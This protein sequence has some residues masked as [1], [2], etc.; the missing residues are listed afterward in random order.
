MKWCS[1]FLALFLLQFPL[2]V[3]GQD[4]DILD[5][6]RGSVVLEASSEYDQSIWSALSLLDSTPKTGWCSAKGAAFP[7]EILLELP[8]T[9]LLE[10]I[11]ID[12]STAQES[13]YPGISAKDIEILASATSPT[14]G[15]TK[16]M[17]VVAPKGARKVF[18]LSNPTKARWLKLV[19]KSNWGDPNY[20][21]IMELEAYGKPAD[22]NP[23][24]PPLAGTF[25][26]NY[27]KIYFETQGNQVKGC[28]DWSGGVL[29]GWTDG[30]VVQFEWRQNK[31][32]QIGTAIMVVSAD[33]KKINGLWYHKGKL[34]GVWVG[35]RAKPGDSANCTVQSGNPVQQA[36]A[37]SGRL[38]TYGIQFDTNLATLKP[39]SKVVLGEVLGALQANP[40]MILTIEGHTDSSASET[41][42]QDLSNRRAQAVVAWLVA[43]GIPAERLKAK[44]FGE[45]RPIADNGTLQGRALNRRV[46]IVQAGKISG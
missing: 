17:D 34:Q 42:N 30:R 32:T 1:L 28:Y 21:E 7:H 26:T 11:V 43:K 4:Q 15:F 44:G 20:S 40:K 14:T 45:A 25:D 33:G 31:G 18:P 35:P 10:K 8:R 38:I 6:A 12:N 16:L 13:S 37:E 29:N 3:Q 23:S 19:I 5:L 2:E 36:L 41:Y 46:E 39:E 9:S 24:Q 22:P 27:N